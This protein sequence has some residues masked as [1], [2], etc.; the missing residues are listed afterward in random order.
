MGRRAA[1][2]LSV[3][4]EN[5]GKPR[6]VKGFFRA[7]FREDGGRRARPAISLVALRRLL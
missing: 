2:Y 6:T 1:D 7:T 4:K 5:I 3:V